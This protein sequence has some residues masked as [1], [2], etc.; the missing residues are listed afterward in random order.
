[1]N[2]DERERILA[3][4]REAQRRVAEARADPEHRG[5]F[6]AREALDHAKEI[7]REHG[8]KDHA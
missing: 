5:L 6:F 7:M 4:Y 3:V 8:V 2:L 1:M